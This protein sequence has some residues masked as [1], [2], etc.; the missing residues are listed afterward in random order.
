MERGIIA[1]TDDGSERRSIPALSVSDAVVLKFGALPALAFSG[2]DGAP[3]T[4]LAVGI[5]AALVLPLLGR[6]LNGLPEWGIRVLRWREA[7]KSSK[8]QQRV[9]RRRSRNARR[10]G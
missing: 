2:A 5:T 8:R 1:R 9:E 7:A 4:I 6:A 3:A 10:R